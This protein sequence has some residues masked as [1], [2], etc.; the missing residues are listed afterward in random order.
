MNNEVFK[1][2]LRF[3]V[4]VAIQVVILNRIHFLGFIN[5]YL[6]VL[7][8]LLLPFE[9]PKWLLLFSSFGIGMLID[10]FSNSYGLHAGAAT[11][12]AF[13]RPFVLRLL[14]SRKEYEPGIHPGLRDLGFNWFLSYS[15]S[16]ILIHHTFLFFVEVFRFTEIFATLFRIFLNTLITLLSVIIAQYLFYR[17]K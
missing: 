1:N 16:L 17:K 14:T 5:P 15:A 2:I 4:L 12:M 6:Y 11:M 3:L 13:S 10:A 7:F 9:T 8:I